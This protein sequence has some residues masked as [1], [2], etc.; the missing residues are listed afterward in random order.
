MSCILGLTGAWYV[1]LFYGGAGFLLCLLHGV[2]RPRSMASKASRASAE[3]KAG[4][5]IEVRACAVS[6]G[7]VG[8]AIAMK[9]GLQ[10]VS[11][12]ASCE[13]PKRFTGILLFR[14]AQ[15]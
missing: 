10:G 7:V 14:L 12:S 1:L 5:T 15:D 6:W 9:G 8:A 4:F 13:F 3:A 11:V 2:F